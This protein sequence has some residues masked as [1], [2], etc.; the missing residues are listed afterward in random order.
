VT[1]DYR[2]SVQSMLTGMDTAQEALV[3]A[4]GKE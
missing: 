4:L 1:V 3:P 2:R